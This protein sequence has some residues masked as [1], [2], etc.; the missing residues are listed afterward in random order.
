ME[1][2][3]GEVEE[4]KARLGSCAVQL[5]S[6]CSPTESVDNKSVRQGQASSSDRHP[7]PSVGSPSVSCSRGTCIAEAPPPGN[8]NS[9]YMTCMQPRTFFSRRA[10]EAK[11]RDQGSVVFA[12][13]MAASFDPNILYINLQ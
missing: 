4:L 6:F 10:K 9:Q 7:H 11:V 8:T 2:P 13:D 5:R 3:W 1:R 12:A